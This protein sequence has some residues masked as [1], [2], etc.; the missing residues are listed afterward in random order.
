MK[1]IIATALLAAVLILPAERA[2]AAVD[3]RM[4]V[5]LMHVPTEEAIGALIKV[6]A[7]AGYTIAVNEPY[8]AVFVKPLRVDRP[9]IYHRQLA[10]RVTYEWKEIDGGLDLWARVHAVSDQAVI[11]LTQKREAAIFYR[12][13]RQLKERYGWTLKNFTP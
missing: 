5:T 10:T 9:L 1:R 4:R 13:M 12:M 8:K 3:P 6:M 2:A 11:P 7:A